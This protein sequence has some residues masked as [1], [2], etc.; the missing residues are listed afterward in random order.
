MV[1]P[2]QTRQAVFERATQVERMIRDSDALGLGPSP[3]LKAHST[4]GPSVKPEP[5]SPGWV[6]HIIAS[7]SKVGG[8]GSMKPPSSSS[9]SSPSSSK[10]VT[11]HVSPPKFKRLTDSEAEARRKLGLCY[12]CDS[13]WFAGHRCQQCELQVMLVDDDDNDPP[14]PPEDASSEQPELV[15]MELSNHAVEGRPMPRTIK[16]KGRVGDVEVVILIDSGASHNFISPALVSTLKLPISV[17]ADYGILVGGGTRISGSGVCKDVSVTFQ[18]FTVFADFFPIP[19]ANS[20]LILGMQWLMTLGMTADD[21]P[22]L[23]MYIQQGD[24][25][26]PLKGD[27]TLHRALVSCRSLQKSLD[28]MMG[29]F[30]VEC[31]S[32]NPLSQ[33]Q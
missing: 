11:P 26:V 1:D 19:M 32:G 15:T 14:N 21:W 27:P 23:T 6:T 31:L 16:V 2:P 18:G 20:D 9:S 28:S 7:P 24:R 10:A 25:W 5:K 4:V 12:R 22:N 33:Q 3:G 30:L 8:S 13:K 17:T 29:C